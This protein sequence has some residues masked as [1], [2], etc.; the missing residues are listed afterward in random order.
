MTSDEQK[1]MVKFV[2]AELAAG[3]LDFLMAHELSHVVKGHLHHDGTPVSEFPW[4][5]SKHFERARST[6]LVDTYLR[7]H[8]PAHSRE[9]EADLEA[10]VCCAGD[11][12]TGAWDLRLMGAEIVLNLISFT[13]RASYWMKHGTDPVDVLGL[14]GYGALGL[15][16]VQLPL[17][18]HPWGETRVT[19]ANNTLS[20]LYG[21]YFSPSELHRKRDLLVA[22]ADIFG[23]M[24]A[25]ALQAVR[26]ASRRP[27]EY[28]AITSYNGTMVTHYWPPDFV[29]GRDKQE[30]MVSR[31]SEFYADITPDMPSG[32]WI[33]ENYG[34]G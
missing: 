11:G 5:D 27:G 18:E 26:W 24:N 22:V 17:P 8:W 12:E 34:R 7:E 15:L 29:V 23:S 28:M 19:V 14:K 30:I 20:A 4:I 16:D 31:A 3:A 6:G 2:H 32:T 21:S 25:R 33:E 10:L 9:M 13:D 1:P